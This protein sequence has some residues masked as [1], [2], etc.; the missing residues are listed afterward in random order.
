M[1]AFA[2]LVGVVLVSDLTAEDLLFF[3]VGVVGGVAGK[4]E[5]SISDS[6]SDELRLTIVE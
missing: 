2:L 6:H 5:S 1:D 3:R 4:L